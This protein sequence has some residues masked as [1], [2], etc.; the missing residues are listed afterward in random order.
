[1]TGFAFIMGCAVLGYFIFR[2]LTK[3]RVVV[4]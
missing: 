3:P 1:M 4:K 2:G